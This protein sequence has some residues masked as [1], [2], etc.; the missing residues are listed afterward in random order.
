MAVLVR[1]VNQGAAGGV[2]RTN[3]GYLYDSDVASTNAAGEWSYKNAQ[4]AADASRYGSE[5]SAEASKFGSKADYDLGMA[6]LGEDQRQFNQQYGTLSGILSG[7]GSGD[8]YARVGGQNTAQQAIDTSPI[9]SDQQIQQRVNAA[10][11]QND[12]SAQSQAQQAAR[13]M[14]GQGFSSAS[15][16]LAALQGQTYNTN[17]AANTQAE[18][19]L[20]W[21]AAEGNKAHV[22]AAQKAAEDQWMDY[23]TADIERRKAAANYYGTIASAL[24]SI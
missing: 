11:A 8:N 20:R 6:N 19:D 2:D 23:N 15:P 13:T 5:L 21:T 1:G 10:R 17:R 24:A 9:W 18:N 7:Y 4:Q 12:A 3:P 16:I 22:L 14:S